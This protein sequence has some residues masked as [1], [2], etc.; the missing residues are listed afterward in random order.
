[1][2]EVRIRRIASAV[3]FLLFIIFLYWSDQFKSSRPKIQIVGN[4]SLTL[5]NLIAK[6][7]NLINFFFIKAPLEAVL[8]SFF[9]LL[10]NAMTFI[11]FTSLLTSFLMVQ[12]SLSMIDHLFLFLSNED[13]L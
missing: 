12:R 3:E 10:S 11:L 4:L 5:N 13:E 2:V 8:P 1:L 9:G 6:V 7:I